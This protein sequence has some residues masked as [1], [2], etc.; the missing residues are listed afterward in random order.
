MSR[1]TVKPLAIGMAGVDVEYAVF[2]AARIYHPPTTVG[3]TGWIQ[4]LSVTRLVVSHYPYPIRPR[5]L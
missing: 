3:H 2:T 4:G 5:T 1:P